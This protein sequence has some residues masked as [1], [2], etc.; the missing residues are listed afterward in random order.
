MIETATH[1]EKGEMRLMGFPVTLNDTPMGPVRAPDTLGEH[2]D[3]ILGE[4]G[5]TPEEIARMRAEK[6]I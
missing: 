1:H 6:L 5:C 4:I 2:T 3:Q